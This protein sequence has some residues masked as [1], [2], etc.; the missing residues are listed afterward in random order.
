[1]D[2]NRPFFHPCFG[3][4]SPLLARI[5]VRTAPQ[6]SNRHMSACPVPGRRPGWHVLALAAVL[7]SGCSTAEIDNIPKE[8]GGLPADAPARPNQAPAYPGIYDTPPQRANALLDAEQQKKLE[9]DLLAV[10]NRQ[11]K[12]QQSAV[13]DKAKPPAASKAKAAEKA[14]PAK[15]PQGQATTPPGTPNQAATGAPPW[16]LPSQTTGGSA[17]P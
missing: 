16:P 8:I 15:R 12:A 9:A 5:P 17:R 2:V 6:M 7:L 10:R 11:I 1:M 3:H 13:R 4:I 14:K